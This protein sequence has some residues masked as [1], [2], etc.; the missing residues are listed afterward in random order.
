LFGL[1]KSPYSH[2]PDTVNVAENIAW[3]FGDKKVI[4]HTENKGLYWQ[5][6]DSW[7]P[8]DPNGKL[9]SGIMEDPASRV[10]ADPNSHTLI[11]EDDLEVSPLFWVHLKQAIERYDN[12]PKIAGYTLQFGTLRA[13]QTKSKSP[14]R[15]DPTTDPIFFYKL[16]GSW[17]Y[18]PKRETWIE[19]R[20]WFH[21]KEP[22]MSFDPT[23]KGLLPSFWF[24]RQFGRQR[25]SMWTMWFI[26]FCHEHGY[27][28]VYANF[29]AGDGTPRTLASNWKERG[30]HYGRSSSSPDFLTLQRNESDFIKYVPQPRYYDWD[31][32]VIQTL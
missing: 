4:L 16:L 3:Q 6:V 1:K 20:K 21:E 27:F 30:M 14:I 7:A 25:K 31:G 32:S 23:V 17:G 26:R 11:L 12:M 5:W 24:K 18:M 29:R 2:D 13:N 19:F 15:F 10:D 22:D 8:K 28:T 9:D